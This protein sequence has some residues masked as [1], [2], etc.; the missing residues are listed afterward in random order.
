MCDFLAAECGV[1]VS[2]SC[3]WRFC[4]DIGHTC[5]CTPRRQ[6][7][8]RSS[9]VRASHRDENG[10]AIGASKG[11]SEYMKRKQ[12]VPGGMP[13]RSKTTRLLEKTR[14]W[15]KEYMSTSDRFDAA[16]DWAHVERVVALSMEILRVEE[17]TWKGKGVKFDAVVVE[18]VALMHDMDEHRYAPNASPQPTNEIDAATSSPTQNEIQTQN[19]S[20]TQGYPS[21][22]TT[23]DPSPLDPSTTV[24]N[25][26]PTNPSI[27][28]STA[29]FVHKTLTYLG[30]PPPLSHHISNLT[31]SIPYTTEHSPR[32]AARSLHTQSLRLY[33]A[34]AIVQDAVRLDMLGAVGIAR[35]I[36]SHGM[37]KGV[38]FLKER[39]VKVERGMKTGE[40]ARL[41][42]GRAAVVRAWLGSWEGEM[43]S[44][45]VGVGV[46]K[47]EGEGGLVR[48]VG[49]GGVE[50]V[51]RWREGVFVVV[52]G[53]VGE[54]RVEAEQAV[55]HGDGGEEGIGVAERMEEGY[56]D[57]ARQL[58]EAA[59]L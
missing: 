10:T 46:G 19:Q 9:S 41:V 48:M 36:A 15:V 51:G 7:D 54:G 3:V 14:N 4:K 53:K 57:P 23:M 31:S 11:P 2:E 47:G 56:G 30:W 39:V 34:H 28:L 6:R 27:H 5:K 44:V 25:T 21:P 32:P 37:D 1:K 33:P 17:Q 26:S 35:A 42:G 58:M 13:S 16:H 55:E 22:D 8:E 49:E 50:K 18:L 40:G 38:E 20:Q 29:P 24:P 12:K 52:E 43:R 45:G 59:G